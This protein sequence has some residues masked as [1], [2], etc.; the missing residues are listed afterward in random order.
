MNKSTSTK[1]FVTEP[2]DPD[3]HDR[4]AF[5]CGV[6]Q[7][8]N[9]FQKTASKLSKADNVRTY[10]KVSA[11]DK[12]K[13]EGFYAINAHSVHYADLPNKYKRAAPGH[14]SIPAVYISMIG[15]DN[16]CKG[17]GVG[18]I[19]LVDALKRTAIGADQFGVAIVMLD[20]LDCG[21]PKAVEKR[22]KTYER[23]GFQPLSSEDLRMF[24]PI[25]TVRKLLDG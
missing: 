6:E 1:Q 3:R 7:V 5:S 24:L 25:A 19:L 2:F 9:Y 13:V 4:A 15:R 10:V 12:T 8:D 20:V 16:T 22:K 17:Q 18:G 14:G 11:G 23:Y 21:D